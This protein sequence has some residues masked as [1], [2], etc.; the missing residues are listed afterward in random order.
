MSTVLK[1]MSFSLP[2]QRCFRGCSVLMEISYL[3]SAYAEV[4]LQRKFQKRLQKAFLCLRR[5]VSH[6]AHYRHYSVELFSAYAE[7]FPGQAR[8]PFSAKAFL[9]LRRGVSTDVFLAEFNV[10][11]SLP[12]Q[13]CFCVVGLDL[14]T[15][16]L[17]SAYAE[18]FPGVPHRHAGIHHF[19]LPTQRCFRHRMGG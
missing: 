8:C 9:C 7:V 4:F 6:P 10:V 16:K 15:R 11:F 5:G 19:S 17:F 3:F 12:T 18:V 13:R 2:T 1:G 14:A